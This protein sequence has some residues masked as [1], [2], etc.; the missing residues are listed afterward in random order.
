[1]YAATATGGP[2]EARRFATTSEDN[3]PARRLRQLLRDLES[4]HF[5]VRQAAEQGLRDLGELAELALS[6]AL[7]ARPTVEAKRRLEQLLA[8][9]NPAGL[10]RGEPLRAVRAIQVLERIGSPEARD[11]LTV[12]AEGL[13]KA[14]LTREAKAALERIGRRTSASRQKSP[15][16]RAP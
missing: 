7:Q 16:S 1:M 10:L 5:A 3:P 8:A 15:A 4:E 13:P 12:L 9:L 14:R 11:V 2:F 6:K